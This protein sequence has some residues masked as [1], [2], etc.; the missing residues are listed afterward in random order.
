MIETASVMDG[1]GAW[2][3][4]PV[5]IEGSCLL[6]KKVGS[7]KLGRVKVRRNAPPKASRGTGVC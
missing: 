6:G 7:G 2:T 1:G 3:L 4:G 5:L